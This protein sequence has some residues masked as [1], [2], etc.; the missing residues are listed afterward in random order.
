[1]KMI[2]ENDVLKECESTD[3]IIVIPD[4]I[5]KIAN[6]AFHTYNWD[7]RDVKQIIIPDSVEEI[8]WGAFSGLHLKSMVI[9]DS[10]KIL[11]EEAFKDCA[12]LESVVIG[13]GITELQS[14]LFKSCYKLEH[15]EIP[16]GLEYV[17]TSAFEECYALRY[18]WLNGV[19][20]HLRDKEAPKPV[21]LVGEALLSCKQRV[22]DY[23]ESG[24]MDEFE[25]IDYQIAGD[26]YSI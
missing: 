4:G 9:P 16:E 1:M 2:I 11:G 20:Y 10:V 25:Y 22:I 18:A 26:G 6:I 21:R 5:R 7:C 3:E 19:K 12:R 17:Y 13:K 14:E 8:G 23:Y 15:L 24:A